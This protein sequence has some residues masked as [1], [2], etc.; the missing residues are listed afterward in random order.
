MLS[1]SMIAVAFRSLGLLAVVAITIL[2]ARAGRGAPARAWPGSLEHVAAYF[3]AAILLC[4]GFID[5]RSAAA[6]RAFAP[7]LSI[8]CLLTAY[9]GTLEI[10]QLFIPGRGPG[11]LDW[12]ADA[13]GAW[14]GVGLV[15]MLRRPVLA[16]LRS[17]YPGKSLPRTRR[18]VDAGFP[19]A[20]SLGT[21]SWCGA[22]L[23]RAKA[24]RKGYAPTH[25]SSAYTKLN[26]SSEISRHVSMPGVD[27]AG[28]EVDAVAQELRRAHRA[29]GRARRRS[30]GPRSNRE[31]PRGS[32]AGPA[33]AGRAA[34]R[35]GECRHA[36]TRIRRSEN[37]KA[38]R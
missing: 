34:E 37:R 30:R 21:V 1:P 18:G 27:R 15:L 14:L 23:R 3:G 20:R 19:P 28:I 31:S 16:A 33:R 8:G 32:R 24:V 17:A 9:G 10:A 22:M 4:L 29:Y 38:S 25:E 35:R 6:E 26:S 36:R 2:L 5:S 7:P 11:M 13:L 12:G